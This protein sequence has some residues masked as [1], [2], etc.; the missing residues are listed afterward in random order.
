M[1]KRKK[2]PA[3]H[4][5]S[6]AWARNKCKRLGIPFV[7]G[8]NMPREQEGSPEGSPLGAPVRPR[9][10]VEDQAKHNRARHRRQRIPSS[11]T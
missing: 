8:G 9:R 10:R 2:S 4:K 11:C 6:R 7:S 1:S 3:R 5:H